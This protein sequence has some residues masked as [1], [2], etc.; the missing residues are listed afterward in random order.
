MSVL[1]VSSRPIPVRVNHPETKNYVHRYRKEV[2]FIFSLIQM[3]VGIFAIM[4]TIT[5]MAVIGESCRWTSC[6]TGYGLWNGVVVSLFICLILIFILF[7]MIFLKVCI[8]V[9]CLKIKTT[10]T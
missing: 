4:L 8:F 10:L 5:E 7:L 3:A 9:E 2:A 6:I 1:E